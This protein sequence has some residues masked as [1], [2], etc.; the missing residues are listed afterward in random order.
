MLDRLRA[1]NDSSVE[2]F[3]VV[4]FAGHVIRLINEAV[5]GRTIG[6]FWVEIELGED[7]I[8]PHDLI[9]G[10]MQM[11]AERRRQL[12]VRRLFDHRRQEPPALQMSRF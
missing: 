2:H 4:N 6:A 7:F 11:V 9:L 12:P 3:L 10:F 5:N 8:E 1:A